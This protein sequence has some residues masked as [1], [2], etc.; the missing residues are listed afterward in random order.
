[1]LFDLDNPSENYWQILAERKQIEALVE[2]LAENKKLV[3]YIK[4]LEIKNHVKSLQGSS[5]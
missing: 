4:K 2:A 1:M 5:G 3:Q